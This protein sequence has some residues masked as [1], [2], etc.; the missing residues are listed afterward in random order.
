MISDLFSMF[1]GA[2]RFPGARCRG[3]HHLFDPAAPSEA[4]ETVAARHRQAVGLCARCPSRAPCEGW[5]S[6]LPAKERPPG[7]VAGAVV[8]NAGRISPASATTKRRS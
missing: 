4:A 5:L 2:P 8:D 3:R 7:I 6:A 1:S